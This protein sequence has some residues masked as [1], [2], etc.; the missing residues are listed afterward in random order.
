MRISI[1]DVRTTRQ[2]NLC[3]LARAV[4]ADVEAVAV[5]RELKAPALTQNP[6]LVLLH[7]GD[8]QTKAGDSIERLLD[9]F[10]QSWILCYSGGMP[11]AAAS[12]CRSPTVAVFPA[13]VF[14][15]DGGD[16]FVRMLHRVF[17]MLPQR[18]TLPESCFR[19]TVMGFD[20]VLEAKL[21]VLMSVLKGEP[22]TPDRLARLKKV[23]PA[24]FDDKGELLADALDRLASADRL[25]KLFFHE[26]VLTGRAECT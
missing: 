14:G 21:D 26:G 6:D 11:A 2:A 10:R 23:C 1:I 4:N 7:V 18:S 24:A 15:E 22:P 17:S 25:R 16:D 8:A 3:K 9:R 13:F 12:A 20:A 19:E 5:A